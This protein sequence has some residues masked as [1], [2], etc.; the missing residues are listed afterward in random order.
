MAMTA[1]SPEWTD[2]APVK[3]SASREIVASPDE[4]FTALADHESWPTWFP[5]MTNV[6]RYGELDDGLGSTRRVSLG[7]VV[8]D[9]KFIVWEPG[10]EWSFTALDIRGAP[11]LLESLNER[12]SIQQLSPDRCRVTYLMALG[13]RRG[14]TWMFD[15]ALRKSVTKTLRNTLSGLDRHLEELSSPRP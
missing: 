7:R 4:I 1:K 13:P 15:K 14:S 11:P 2:R 5:R 9:E 8:V 12:V 6:E 10:K 3:I